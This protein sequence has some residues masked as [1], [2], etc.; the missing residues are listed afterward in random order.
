MRYTFILTLLFVVNPVFAAEQLLPELDE[1]TEIEAEESPYDDL[2]DIRKQ[3]ENG[4]ITPDDLLALLEL[5]LTQRREAG[6]AELAEIALGTPQNIRD[7]DAR[8]K[9]SLERTAGRRERGKKDDVVYRGRKMYDGLLIYQSDARIN[10]AA[11]AA[12]SMLNQ[13]APALEYLNI[14][15]TL[16]PYYDEPY[17]NLGLFY[18]IKGKYET[19][20]IQY[21]KALDITPT[22]PT[23][24]YNKGIVQIRLGDIEGA[25]ES[26]KRSAA[27]DPKFRAPVRRTA[28]IWLDIGDYKEA[29]IYLERLEYQIETADD[30]P[31]GEEIEELKSLIALTDTKLG[32]NLS[33]ESKE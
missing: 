12:Y 11:G 15:R 21:D 22:N 6:V 16:D 5:G 29:D 33:T 3:V 24:W 31:T 23:T 26:F 32:K 17:A 20:Q 30:K 9:A 2:F 28:L 25:L 1:E 14:A 8:Y 10:N 18:R 27:L 19:A 7:E 4:E 13:S